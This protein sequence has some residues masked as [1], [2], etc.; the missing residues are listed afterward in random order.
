MSKAAKPDDVNEVLDRVEDAGD[1]ETVT[2]GE[3]VEEIGGG[4]FG[5]LLLVPALFLVTPASGVP[6]MPSVGSLIISLIA[7]QIVLGRDTLWLPDFLLRREI[8]RARLDK[9]LSWLRKPAGWIDRFSS[10]RLAFLTQRPWIVL[11]AGLCALMVLLAPAFEMVPFSVS[12][13]AGA[14]ALFALGIVARDGLMIVL[15][16]IVFAAAGWLIVPT[17]T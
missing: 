12:I 3:I 15:G 11:P 2:L 10:E 13:A 17:L 7:I 14:V 4:A 1:D 6:G 16:L 9:A 5:A 8:T